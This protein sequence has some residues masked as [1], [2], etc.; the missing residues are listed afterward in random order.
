MNNYS[1]FQE[2]KTYNYKTYSDDGTKVLKEVNIKYLFSYGQNAWM[3]VDR[4]FLNSKGWKDYHI[5]KNL[6]FPEE[7]KKKLN[8]RRFRHILCESETITYDINGVEFSRD[9]KFTQHDKT[10]DIFNYQHGKK[11]NI[12]QEVT[13]RTR[14][15][16]TSDKIDENG[17]PRVV[18]TSGAIHYGERPTR[19]FIV[20]E[21]RPSEVAVK[22]FDS[23]TIV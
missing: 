6:T 12:K 11:L 1:D 19:C 5:E 8:D 17:N 16:Y 7:L 10:S 13:S 22:I 2:G 15:L 23:L 18:L 9:T 14:T 21:G 20:F 3:K 4:F